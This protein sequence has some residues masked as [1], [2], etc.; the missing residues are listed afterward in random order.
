MF[1]WAPTLGGE[2]YELDRNPAGMTS[3]ICFNGHPPLGVNATR[4]VGDAAARYSRRFQWAP[5]LGGECY[6]DPAPEMVAQVLLFQWAPTLGGECYSLQNG[7][8]QVDEEVFQWAPTL[9]GECYA[10]A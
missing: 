2:C 10:V 8:L 5:T 4:R 9:G 7:F 6:D 1:Q 3:E